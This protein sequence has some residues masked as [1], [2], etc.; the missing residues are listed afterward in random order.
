VSRYE[1]LL[2]LHVLSAFALVA[3]LVIFT[4]LLATARDSRPSPLL[5]ISWL[6]SR[7]WDVGVLGTLVFGVWMATDI[8]N[9]D[10]LDGWILAALVLW[11]IAAGAGARVGLAYRALRD[12]GAEVAVVVRTQQL[13]MIVAATLLLVDMIFK[14]GV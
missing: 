5:G 7:L 11:V 12:E 4:A 2:F 14:P 3:S 13:V 1:W 8:D 6:G 10:L 9:Y